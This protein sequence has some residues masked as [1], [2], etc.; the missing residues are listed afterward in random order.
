MGQEGLLIPGRQLQSLGQSPERLSKL[1]EH[2]SSMYL[3]E[4]I[5]WSDVFAL[6]K[7]DMEIAH[8]PGQ[9]HPEIIPHHDDALDVL[10]VTLP[11]ALDQFGI[12]LLP[13]GVQPLLELVENDEDLLL[14]PQP[15]P[16][17]DDLLRQ[18][19]VSGQVGKPPPYPVEQSYLGLLGSRL[20]I[21]EGD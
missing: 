12:V 19:H 2:F 6:N 13:P 8:E 15:L 18:I 16:E 7:F 14:R 9:G 10:A 5:D 17:S 11:K 4:Q 21:D 20:D 3:I 1:G